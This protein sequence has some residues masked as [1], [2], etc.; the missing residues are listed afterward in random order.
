MGP[1]Y[2]QGE[3]EGQNPEMGQAEV[4]SRD[5]R[6]RKEGPR[7]RK[8]RRPLGAAED[9]GQTPCWRSGSRAA[10]QYFDVAPWHPLSYNHNW[11]TRNSYRCFKPLSL[12]W[13]VPTA[14]RNQHTPALHTRAPL[15]GAP[16]LSSHYSVSQ[17]L[18]PLSRKLPPTSQTRSGPPVS[19]LTVHELIL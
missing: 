13:S 18:Y 17:L 15:P 3:L 4:M 12:R 16:P 9:E 2:S 19:L 7:P 1:V 5:W 11:M 6:D 8:R 10:P 14:R